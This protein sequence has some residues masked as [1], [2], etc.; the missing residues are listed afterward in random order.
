ML[1]SWHNLYIGFLICRGRTITIEKVKWKPPALSLARKIVNFQ[2]WK[3]YQHSHHHHGFEG[4]TGGDSHHIHIQLTYL[5]HIEDR[6]IL[7]S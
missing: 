5:A 6:W 1:A 7:E 4:C 2:Y 3:D